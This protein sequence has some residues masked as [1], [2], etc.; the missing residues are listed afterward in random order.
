[1]NKVPTR[2][3]SVVDGPQDL[4]AVEPKAFKDKPPPPTELSMKGRKAYMKGAHNRSEFID[5]VTSR[6]SDIEFRILRPGQQA[7]LLFR[8]REENDNVLE[9]TW[10][11]VF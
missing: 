8:I 11:P 1:M 4:T 6:A 5:Y 2:I 3:D 7:S 9:K 10:Q